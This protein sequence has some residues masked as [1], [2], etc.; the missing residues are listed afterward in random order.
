MKLSKWLLLG[1]LLASGKA[2]A[3]QPSCNQFK[4]V[5]VTAGNTTEIV[6]AISGNPVR[7]CLFSISMSAAG[8]AKSCCRTPLVVRQPSSDA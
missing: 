2:F 5:S 3:Q 8:T 1:L 7:V 6:A 4:T